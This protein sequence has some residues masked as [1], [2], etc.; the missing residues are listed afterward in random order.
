MKFKA[1]KKALAILLSIMLVIPSLGLTAIISNAAPATTK[2]VT[3]GELVAQNYASLTDAEKAILTSGQ[4]IGDSYTY[5]VP[6]NGDDLV[7]IDTDAKTITA[8]NY[9]DTV[10]G[11]TWVPA[12][13]RIVWSEGSESIT[14]N[15]GVASYNY[16][17][18]PF[19]AE[20][21]YAAGIAVDSDLQAALL[22]GPLRLV[23]GLDALEEF[24]RQLAVYDAVGAYVDVFN[25][26]TPYLTDHNAIGAITALKNEVDANGAV[27]ILDYALNYEDADDKVAYLFNHG[28]AFRDAAMSFRWRVEDIFSGP[29]VIVAIN[30]HLGG[31]ARN[32]ALRVL[33]YFGN[34]LTE[35]FFAANYGWEIL[36]AANNPFKV[37]ADTALLGTLAAAIPSHA[38]HTDAIVSDLAVPT[39]TVYANEAQYD[40]YL[41]VRVNYIPD[42]TVDSDT[43]AQHVK[44]AR[45]KAYDGASAA[46]VVSTIAASGVEAFALA[47][48]GI[49]DASKFTRT[50]TDL[51]GTVNGDVYYE[52]EFT[53]NYY[54]INASFTGLPASVPYGYGLTLPEHSDPERVYDYVV[55]GEDRLQGEVVVITGDTAIT[56]AEGNPWAVH[57]INEIVAAN[58]DAELT[59]DEK[60]VLTAVALGS[61]T[62]RFRAPS[63]NDG[64]ITI[65][66]ASGVMTV[67]AADYASGIPGLSWTAVSGKA[68]LDGAEVR[69]FDFVSGEASFPAAEIDNVTVEYKLTLTNVSDARVLESLNAPAALA[70]E[71]GRQLDALDLLNGYYNRFAEFDRRAINRLQVGINGATEMSQAS[72]DAVNVIVNA[73]FD[74]EADALYLLGHLDGYR[75][76]GLKYYYANNTAFRAQVNALY[77]ALST[78]NSDPALHNLLVDIGYEEYEEKIQNVVNTLTTVVSELTEPD[79]FINVASARL[80]ELTGALTRLVGNGRSFSATNG[81]LTVAKTLTAAAPGRSVITLTVEQRSSSD[82]LLKSESGTVVVS[83]LAPLA[84]SDVNKIEDKLAALVA[85]AGIDTAHYVTSDGHG[86]FVG[87]TVDSDTDVTI[88]YGPNTYIVTFTENGGVVGYGSFPYDNP[89]VTLPACDESGM[90]YQYD[91]FG[92]VYTVRNIAKDVTLRGAQIGSCTIDRVKINISRNDFI[93][94][95]ERSNS[96]IASAGLSNGSGNLTAAFIPM[97][98]AD[99][100]LA[101]LFRISPQNVS[102]FDDALVN[103]IE[104]FAGSD[105]KYI[106]LDGHYIREGDLFSLQGVIDAALNSGISLDTAIGLIAPNGDIIESTISGGYTVI[107]ATGNTIQVGSKT[108]SNTDVVGGIFYEGILNLAADSADPGQNVKL[109]VSVEDFDQSADNLK[110]IRKLASKIRNRGNI[111]LRDGR[112]DVN[113]TLPERVNQAFIGGLLAL[114]R[115][116]VKAFDE[117]YLDGLAD[118]ALAYVRAVVED[119]TVTMT[120][121][122]N[123]LAKVGYDFD[124]SAYERYF[125]K[126]MKAARHIL[127]NITIS[128][129][130]Y[131]MT[132]VSYAADVNYDL[133]AAL[134]HFN[135]QDTL[136]GILKENDTGVNASVKLTVNN[137]QDYEAIIADR[138]QPGLGKLRFTRDLAYDARTLRGDSVIIL[139][140]DFD[141]D[142]AFNKRVVFDL[143]GKTVNGGLRFANTAYVVDSMLDT[144]SGARVTGAVSG[145]VVIASGRYEQDVSAFL[146]DGYVLDGGLVRSAFYTITGGGYGYDIHLIADADALRDVDRATVKALALDIAADVAA[147]YYYAAGMDVNGD[148]LFELSF[149]DVL[150]VLDGGS[151]SEINGLIRCGDLGTLNDLINDLIDTLCDFTAVG[152]AVK[153]GDP[154]KV[155]DIETANWTFEVDHVAAGDY[156]TANAA[157]ADTYYLDEE[158]RIYIDDVHGIGDALIA[159]GEVATADADAYVDDIAYIGNRTVKVT[160]HGSGRLDVDLTGDPNFAVVIGVIL[161][162]GVTDTSKKAALAAGVMRYYADGTL[163]DLKA[164]FDTVTTAELYRAFRSASSLESKITALGL[165]GMVGS[166]A[167]DLYNTYKNVLKIAFKALDLANVEGSGTT[168]AQLETNFGEY[169]EQKTDKTVTRQLSRYT[170]TLIGE[171]TLTSAVLDVKIFPDY[172]VL[173]TDA[174]GAEQYR[175]DDLNDGFLAATVG[176]TVKVVREVNLENDYD[177]NF[178]VTFKGTG[179]VTFNAGIVLA[180]LAAELTADGRLTCVT[181]G[182][183]D[184]VVKETDNGDGTF[185]YTLEHDKYTVTFN[186]NG[187][188]IFGEA[189]VSYRIGYGE[190]YASAIGASIPRP[191]YSGY[192]FDGWVCGSYTLTSMQ[193]VYAYEQD[194]EFTA[195]WRPVVPGFI[196]HVHDLD[197]NVKDVFVLSG[198]GYTDYQSI[199]YRGGGG[200]PGNQIGVEHDENDVAVYWYRITPGKFMDSDHVDPDGHKQF[201]DFKVDHEDVYTV[202]IRYTDGTFALY[203]VDIAATGGATVTTENQ[204]VTVTLDPTNEYDLK[205]FRYAPGTGYKTA[206]AIKKAE[207]SRSFK[208]DRFENDQFIFGVSE[209]GTYTYVVEFIDG[210]SRIGTFE[211]TNVVYETPDITSTKMA[212]IPADIVTIRYV[213]G[214]HPGMT[215]S[216]AKAAGALAI[217][218]DCFVGGEYYFKEKLVGKYT[219]VFTYG[220]THSEYALVVDIANESDKFVVSSVPELIAAIAAAGEGDEIIIGR[221]ITT[222][223]TVTI[224]LNKSVTIFMNRKDLG[225]NTGDASLFTINVAAGKALTLTGGGNL[226]ATVNGTVANQDGTHIG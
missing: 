130:T 118:L 146:K 160:G 44:T 111:V 18:G 185:T 170:A 156:L 212:H 209:A 202:F 134:D 197:E 222:A 54:S 205:V 93:D 166:D 174:S 81:P 91:V 120:T 213:A 140:K 28:S 53:P 216:E 211:V 27:R 157:A 214:E 39:E 103:V 58:Y 173:T 198:D 121:I 29:E 200:N 7:S 153:A 90:A 12:T 220:R 176:S 88:V 95:V 161:A 87:Q 225:T 144:D 125:G 100:E 133:T 215:M 89:V 189:T 169:V 223:K 221:H 63:N 78:I 33:G 164:A 139:L 149:D 137:D 69:S 6:E 116:N 73:C 30:D 101:L 24:D 194:V 72:K 20:V 65:A 115:K 16:E 182:V 75:A 9:A 86:F 17:G 178:A 97:E 188:T 143:N 141:G 167:I 94:L 41:T 71:A 172:K 67:T 226:I 48:A 110:N 129:E 180:D 23:N 2:T 177:L 50:A 147:K 61:D 145:P 135:V 155:Y 105:F 199:K 191:V 43:T 25:S 168:M 70:A 128:N 175:G 203:T 102:K 119:D 74:R 158:Y 14:F 109:Y 114:D 193:D 22:N 4:V 210:T 190:T 184:Y 206:N 179:L 112:I 64:L 37:D 11:L 49:T 108:I 66:S 163:A 83:G 123:T 183:T 127:N 79:V 154:V 45:L 35:T 21:D 201:Y 122:E 32:N 186:A 52:I 126:A 152:N 150:S 124:G 38:P 80:G 40:V 217:T 1:L 98:N 15:S 84:Q 60:A 195:Q 192:Q 136:R 113:V 8:A 151:A 47:E 31:S 92:T 117:L 181:S 224:D 76:D 85:A 62:V 218:S 99:G 142:L 159:L 82:E 204:F 96:G 55:N 13:G 162:D 171:A 46:T 10:G 104:E 36:D 56:R 148:N 19:T 196:I 42:G 187:G 59:A 34:F 165:D 219:F 51:T 138:G 77:D 68:Y 131:G 208:Y 5:S 132:E 57:K 106:S 3:D 26:L 207:G 107:G